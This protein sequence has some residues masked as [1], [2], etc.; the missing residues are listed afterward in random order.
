M[1]VP[2][3]AGVGE[4]NHFDGLSAS[5]RIDRTVRT[6]ANVA[7]RVACRLPLH[8]PATMLFCRDKSDYLF[9]RIDSAWS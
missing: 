2:C 3:V 9:S 8:R 4:G 1:A 7:Y 5:R 6:G